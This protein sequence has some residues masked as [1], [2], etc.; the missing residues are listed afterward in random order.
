MG[1][2]P[3]AVLFSSLL[4]KTTT[5]GSDKSRLVSALGKMVA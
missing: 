3:K 2:L 5:D 1:S 4:N